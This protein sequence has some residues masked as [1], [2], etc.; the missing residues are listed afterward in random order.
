M[1]TSLPVVASSVVV[2][3]LFG[4]AG[5][6]R[7]LGPLRLVE[8]LDVQKYLGRWYE[9]ARFTKGFEKNIVGAAAEYSLRDDGRIRVVNSGFRATLDGR[10]TE[11]KG[12]AWRPDPR[13]PAAFKVSFFWPFAGDYLVFGLDQE[14][15]S[16]ALVGANSREYLWFLA[17]TPEISDELYQKMRQL[18]QDQGYDLSTLYKV[19]QKAR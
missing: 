16:W 14:S 19:P 15:Y 3:A 18:A 5:T 11:A 8:S 9:I 12:V 13:R 6:P 7:A 4:C 1:K 10:Y 17:R 2:L